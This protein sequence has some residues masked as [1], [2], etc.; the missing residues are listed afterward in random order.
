MHLWCY[1]GWLLGVDDRWLPHTERQGRRLLYHFLANDPPPDANS[2]AL[3]RALI[4]MTD[5]ITPGPR[6]RFERERALSHRGDAER[7]IG[8]ARDENDRQGDVRVDHVPLER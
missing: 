7:H 4:E 5:E 3:A 1:V 8:I 6:Q 2:V